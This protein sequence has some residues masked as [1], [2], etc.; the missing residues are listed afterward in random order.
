MANLD[1]TLELDQEN[2]DPFLDILGIF[3]SGEFNDVAQDKYR[4][5][6]DAIHAEF[7]DFPTRIS[8]DDARCDSR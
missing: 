5:I 6:A 2:H 7:S 8:N 1:E 4:H 3:S